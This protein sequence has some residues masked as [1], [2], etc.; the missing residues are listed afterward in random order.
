MMD[1]VK[2]LLVHPWVVRG[3]QLV[4]GAVFV[5]AALPKVTDPA[6]FATSVHNFRMIPVPFEN[7]VAL[8]LPWIE[9]V[10][11]L[12]LIL[13][14]EPRAGGLVAATL[15]VVFTIAVATALA[16]GLDIECGCFGTEDGARVGM[17]KLFENIG[18][19]ALA[20]I[21]ALRP[22]LDGASVTVPASFERRRTVAGS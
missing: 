4:I 14:I 5:W 13:G 3:A 10:V 21:A 7:L 1:S 9:L 18:L 22:R 16:R 19:T 2:R 6:S 12:A 15:M 8:T 17:E 11:G 20:A